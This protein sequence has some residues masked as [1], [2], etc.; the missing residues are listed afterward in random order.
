[1]SLSSWLRGA[2]RIFTKQEEY[3]EDDDMRVVIFFTERNY[4]D[5]DKV[6]RRP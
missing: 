6:R 5:T 1:M 2:M 3:Q 4:E